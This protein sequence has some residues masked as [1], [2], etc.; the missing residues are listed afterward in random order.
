MKREPCFFNV[1]GFGFLKKG[2]SM[3]SFLPV[4]L[5]SLCLGFLVLGAGHALAG[6][7]PAGTTELSTALAFNHAGFS[8]EDEDLGSTTT[9]A[10]SV[11][12]GQC[13]TN[14]LEIQ[15]ALMFAH[16]SVSPEGGDSESASSFGFLGSLIVNFSTSGPMV[17]Y[18]QGG[19]GLQTYSGDGYEGA[20]TSSIV[21]SVGGGLRFLIGDSASIN[22][23]LTYQHVNNA[24]GGEDITANEVLFTVGVSVLL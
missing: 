21:P 17:P 13:V 9:L 22:A 7:M 2:G 16:N 4:S 23:G 10:L 18:V 11:G 1:F 14:M 24:G 19:I 15:G 3:R 6:S 5:V 8:F 12:V 20:E